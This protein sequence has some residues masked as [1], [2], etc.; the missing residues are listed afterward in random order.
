MGGRAIWYLINFRLCLLY[1]FLVG[2]KHIYLVVN[3]E[4]NALI[5]KNSVRQGA[6]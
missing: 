2:Q 6:I 4:T 3:V 5:E 1:V